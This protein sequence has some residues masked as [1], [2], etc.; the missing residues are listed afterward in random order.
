MYAYYMMMFPLAA[1][2]YGEIIRLAEKYC[3]SGRKRYN[4]TGVSKIDDRGCFMQVRKVRASQ[5]R[6]PDNVWWR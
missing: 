5:G 6:M 1:L 4:R 3:F 2:G